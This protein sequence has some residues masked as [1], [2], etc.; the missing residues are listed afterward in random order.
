MWII[1]DLRSLKFLTSN[2]SME[3]CTHF[4]PQT[5]AIGVEFKIGDKGRL[6]DKYELD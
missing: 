3:I 1:V 2:D 4:Y 5:K 6:K